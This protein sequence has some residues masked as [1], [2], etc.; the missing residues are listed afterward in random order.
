MLGW[1]YR[2]SGTYA[3]AVQLQK[4]DKFLKTEKGTKLFAYF[5]TKRC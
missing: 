1:N 5:K 3:V 4:L 2:I